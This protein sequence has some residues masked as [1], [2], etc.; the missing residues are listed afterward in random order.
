[1]RVDD[2]DTVDPKLKE[3][4]FTEMC[5]NNFFDMIKEFYNKKLL[6]IHFLTD[7]KV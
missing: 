2:F 4:T 3:L 6:D 1:L 5:K 7:L